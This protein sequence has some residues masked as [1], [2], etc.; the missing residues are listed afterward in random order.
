M[1]EREES[2]RVCVCEYDCMCA[3]EKKEV[4]PFGSKSNRK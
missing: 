2:V 4:Q 1:C 3:Q